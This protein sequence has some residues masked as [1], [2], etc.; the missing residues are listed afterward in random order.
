MEPEGTE[1]PDAD[2]PSDLVRV[3][4]LGVPRRAQHA[5]S[6]TVLVL[7]A[8]DSAVR[9]LQDVTGLELRSDLA[10][11]DAVDLVLVF[12][13]LPRSELAGLLAGPLADSP[14]PLVGVVHTGGEAA[15]VEIARAGAVSIL[16]EGNEAA[17]ATVLAGNAGDP[18][19]LETFARYFGRQGHS[20]E[21][22]RRDPATGLPDRTAFDDRLEELTARGDVPRIGFVR[23]TGLA[24]ASRQLGP[25]AAALLR[26]RLAALALHVTR[27]FDVEL[28]AGDVADLLVLG[29]TLSPGRMEQLGAQL[30]ATMRAFSFAHSGPLAVAIGHAGAEAGDTTALLLELAQRA[31]QVAAVDR[32]RRVIGAE[33]LALGVSAT[34]ELEAATR[35][36]EHV[37]VRGRHGAGH[38][39]RV[40]SW[41]AEL[42]RGLGY[43]VA[44]RNV[45]ELAGRLHE[46]GKVGLPPACWGGPYDLPDELLAAYR[47][48]PDRSARYLAVSAGADVAAAVASIHEWWDGSGSP[49]GHA[50]PAI[51]VS[52]RLLAVA[53]SMEEAVARSHGDVE[54]AIA[55]LR[56]VAG[57]RL[58]PELVASVASLLTARPEAALAS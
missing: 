55:T 22:R 49:D 21:S 5:A 41:A 38:G 36:V 25:V 43:E 44:L 46:V 4:Q 56:E 51:P 20:D 8:P 11:L 52:A 27:P 54:A 12:S 17:V 28:Y 18:T 15:A 53:H 24:D 45:V 37:E 2:T 16:A 1:V 30:D 39:E 50:G 7:G 35:I 58:D 57:T 42:A 33:S 9:R 29:P 19:L 14:V 3:E 34:T 26:R 47:T 40:A 13:R 32:G 10:E 23:V 48:Y 6:G 31:M